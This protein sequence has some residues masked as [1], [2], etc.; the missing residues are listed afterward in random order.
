MRPRFCDQLHGALSM[1]EQPICQQSQCPTAGAAR[2]KRYP[3]KLKALSKRM[4]FSPGFACSQIGY[5]EAVS[6]V[7]EETRCSLTGYIG[8]SAALFRLFEDLVEGNPV[9]TQTA[10]GCGEIAI[11]LADGLL[12]QIAFLRE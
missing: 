11:A 3:T 4:V 10:C 8:K 1:P 12:N 7:A 2:P 9:D 6:T 5:R